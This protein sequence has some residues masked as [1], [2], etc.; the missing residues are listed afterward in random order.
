MAGRFLVR[1]YNGYPQPLLCER[2]PGIIRRV[3]VRN[4]TS[5]LSSHHLKIY[6][7]LKSSFVRILAW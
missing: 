4:H 6:S 3:K 1:A 5:K 2:S 7:N